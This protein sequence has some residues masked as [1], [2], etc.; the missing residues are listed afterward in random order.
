MRTLVRAKEMIT[1][2]VDYRNFVEA[3]DSERDFVLSDTFM[4]TVLE[5]NE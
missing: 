4:Y 1:K 3:I 2:K 5:S